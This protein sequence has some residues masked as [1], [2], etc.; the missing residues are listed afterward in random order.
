MAIEWGGISRPA[1]SFGRMLRDMLVNLAEL[2]L[3]TAFGGCANQ[4]LYLNFTP[5]H[6]N[7]DL[8]AL[9]NNFRVIGCEAIPCNLPISSTAPG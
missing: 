1:K 7:V 9:A 8:N 4:L 6:A 3:D 2:M 5:S